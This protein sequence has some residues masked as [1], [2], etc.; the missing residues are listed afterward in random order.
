MEDSFVFVMVENGSS[1]DVLLPEKNYMIINNDAYPL[2]CFPIR[3]PVGPSKIY[4]YSPALGSIKHLETVLTNDAMLQ[5]CLTINNSRNVVDAHI[6]SYKLEDLDP[7]ILVF[8]KEKSAESKALFEKWREAYGFMPSTTPVSPGRSAPSAPS[9]PSTSYEERKGGKFIGWGIALM[10]LFSI[11]VI[12]C[13][14]GEI[15]Y[16][17]TPITDSFELTNLHVYIGGA[18]IGLILFI[19]GLIRRY[20]RS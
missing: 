10:I 18:A 16:D 12:G 11:G 7:R 8:C 14:T 4:I 2:G 3:L 17:A 6:S 5:I 13:L 1:S 9:A 15:E 19:V 20:K